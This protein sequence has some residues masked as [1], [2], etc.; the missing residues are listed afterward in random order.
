MCAE[1]KSETNRFLRVVVFFI[2]SFV[3]HWCLCLHTY[4]HGN[5]YWLFRYLHFHALIL[6]FFL[7]L[8][9][10]FC[11]VFLFIYFPFIYAFVQ[12]QKYLHTIL[13]KNCKRSTDYLQKLRT[14]NRDGKVENNAMRDRDK[15]IARRKQ[16]Q[17]YGIHRRQRGITGQ[18]NLNNRLKERQRQTKESE[19][20]KST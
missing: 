13:I 6:F 17:T 16:M 15:A 5:V 7:F 19:K 18:R 9:R 3:S 11:F 8:R 14:G 2:R 10:L 4:A 20:S 12:Y 1:F